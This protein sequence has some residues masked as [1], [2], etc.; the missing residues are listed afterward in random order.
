MLIFDHVR[1][2]AAPVQRALQDGV[3][4]TGVSLAFTVRELDAGPIIASETIEVDDKYRY[5]CRHPICLNS[6][7]IKVPNF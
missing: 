5:L 4:E 7:F 1:I 2:S 6:C 3:K